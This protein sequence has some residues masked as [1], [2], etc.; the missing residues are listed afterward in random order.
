[1]YINLALF[2]TSFRTRTRLYCMYLKVLFGSRLLCVHGP[3]EEKKLM[4]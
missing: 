2:E 4:I 1:M 3:L